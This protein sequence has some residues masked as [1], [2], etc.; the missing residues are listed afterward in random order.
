MN[1]ITSSINFFWGILQRFFGVF[2]T[3]A[4]S[5]GIKYVS[6]F[7]ITFDKTTESSQIGVVNIRVALSESFSEA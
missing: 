1:A 6:F 3:L 4:S 5:L 7:F 2:E